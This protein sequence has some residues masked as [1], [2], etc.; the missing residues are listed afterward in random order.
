MI[1]LLIVCDCSSI[2]FWR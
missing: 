1:E 2:W